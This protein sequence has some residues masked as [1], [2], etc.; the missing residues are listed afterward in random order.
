MTRSFRQTFE[1][2]ENSIGARVDGDGR[3]V[4]PRR[5][6]PL[7]VDDEERAL[8]GAVSLG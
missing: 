5:M 3:D 8:G 6:T 1:R 4:A 7:L 2:L